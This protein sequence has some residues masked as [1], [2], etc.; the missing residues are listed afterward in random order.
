MA[1]RYQFTEEQF[2]ELE[3]ARKSNKD[4]NVERRIRALLMRRQGMKNA[5]I[6][7]ATGFDKV[8]L[9]ELFSKYAK[10]G[11]E[12]I[13]GKHYKG[14][15]RNLSVDEER[16]LLCDFEKAAVDGKI[17]ETREIK[18]KYEQMVGHEI[19]SGQIYRVLKRQGWRKVLPRSRHP[20]KASDEAIE[21]SKKLTTLW[22]PSWKI[23]QIMGK[24]CN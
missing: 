15:R 2:A 19:G 16:A 11:L 14:N 4:K 24:R 10:G 23:I 9:S 21:A 22:L 7:K 8:Y 18:A 6:A 5:E 3:A 20:K 17:V 12:A 13:E 1:A